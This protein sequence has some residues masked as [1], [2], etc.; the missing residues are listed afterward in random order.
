VASSGEKLHIIVTCTERKT[1]QVPG[2]LHLRDVRGDESQTRAAHWIERLVSEVTTPTVPASHLYAGEHWVRAKALPELAS[3]MQGCLWTCSAGY[4]LIRGEAPLRPYAATLSPGHADSVPGGKVGAANWWKAL[5]HW[6]GPDPGQ[7]RSFRELAES[8]PDATFLLVLSATYLQACRRD[9]EAAASI[10]TPGRFMIVSA[11]TVASAPLTR[12]LLPVNA[13]LQAHLGGTRQVLNVRIAED[14]LKRQLLSYSAAAN[15]LE[16]VMK[17]YPNAQRWD[18]EKFS[19]DTEVI[20][21]I[22]DEYECGRGASASRM[23]RTLRE[24]GRA[25]EQKRFGRLHK[26]FLDDQQCELIG[27]QP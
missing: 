27:S 17:S 7:P 5:A 25:C 23:L 11:G 20:G 13:R 21:W 4:G 12:Q 10:A 16:D 26:Q 6:E 18:R 19:G 22:R 15:Y 14:L 1:A 2:P 8:D 9:I 3:D 24:S